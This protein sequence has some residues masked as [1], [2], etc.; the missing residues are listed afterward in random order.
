MDYM[1]GE[2]GGGLGEMMVATNDSVSFL[3]KIFRRRMWWHLKTV[4]YLLI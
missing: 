3:S 4:N 2:I 1:S